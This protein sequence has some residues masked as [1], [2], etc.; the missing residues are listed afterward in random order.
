[1]EGSF[2]RGPLGKGELR[3][4]GLQKKNFKQRQR[5]GKKKR[6]LS[7]EGFRTGDLE[8][9]KPAIKNGEQ[10]SNGG[11]NWDATSPQS[12]GTTLL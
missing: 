11:T 12:H 3:S 6:Q 5:K 8:K 10:N 2:R 9:M 1:L 7:R 4:A